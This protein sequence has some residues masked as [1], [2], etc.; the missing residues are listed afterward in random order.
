MNQA[1]AAVPL[2]SPETVLV[3]TPMDATIDPAEVVPVSKT[4]ARARVYDDLHAEFAPQTLL[5]VRGQI[6]R[7]TPTL[8]RSREQKVNRR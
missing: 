7:E 3:C 4:P 2:A 5:V 8:N 6:A 1:L